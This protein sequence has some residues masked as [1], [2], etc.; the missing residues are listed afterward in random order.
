MNAQVLLLELILKKLLDLR[1]TD[2][3]TNKLNHIYLI[4]FDAGF[5]KNLLDWL[6]DSVKEC[7]GLL[8]EFPSFNQGLKSDRVGE[9]A[10]LYLNLLV[11]RENILVLNNLFKKTLDDLGVL[12]DVRLALSL[13]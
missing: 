6:H 1:D 4:D 10:Q 8:L 2:T 7:R 13:L 5:F 3:T 11:C 9:L 12:A